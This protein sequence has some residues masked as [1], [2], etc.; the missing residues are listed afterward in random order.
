[1]RISSIN[2]IFI[3]TKHQNKSSKDNNTV[4]PTPSDVR[5][6]KLFPYNPVVLSFSGVT[7]GGEKLKKLVRYGIPDMYTG[8][9]LLDPKIL[10]YLQCKNIFSNPL[11]YLIGDLKPYEDTLITSGKGFY[12]LLKNTA[13]EYPN[14]TISDVIKMNKKEHEKLLLHD[15]SGIFNKLIYKGMDLPE[16]PFE[17]FQ[18]LTNITIKRLMNDP[19]VLP[20]SETEFKYKL[21]RISETIKS[22]NNKQEITA[23]RELE[24]MAGKLFKG[25]MDFVDRKLLNYNS[26][27]P[28]LAVKRKEKPIKATLRLKLEHQMKPEVLK[29][30]ADNLAKMREYYDSSV[31]KDNEELANLFENTNAKIHGFPYYAKFERKS[32]LY[33]LKKITKQLKDRD[34]AHEMMNIAIKLPTSYENLSAFIVK[35]AGDTSNKIGY[36]MMKDS[37]VSIDHLV[38]KKGGGANT[39]KNFGLSSAGVNREKSNIPFDEFVKMHPETYENCQKQVDRLI[40]LCNDGTFDKLEIPR[41]Y[42]KDFATTILNI[43]PPEKRIILDISKLNLNEE[44]LACKKSK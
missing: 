41:S 25:S 36:H 43:S 22:K 18:V 3:E 6:N 37:V 17:D 16:G 23:M 39:L 20:F 34:F 24:K 11:K 21:K 40:E 9:I 13:K 1:M 4:N 27:Y 7:H 5:I 12:E 30:N 8:Q 29:K 14:Y 42:I 32:F 28:N 15:Q 35:Y 38:P 10:E 33:E 44:T 2:N 19:V 26:I 31:L